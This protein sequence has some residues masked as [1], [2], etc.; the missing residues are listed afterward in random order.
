[1]SGAA[2]QP[3][4][5]A[6]GLLLGDGVEIGEGVLIGGYADHPCRCD[7]RRR[8]ADRR[9]RAAARRR[10]DRRRDDD[11]QL[12][13]ASTPRSRS[14]PGSACRPAA[15]SPAAPSIEDDVF[16]GPG[17]TLTNDNTMDRHEPGHAFRRSRSCAAPAG[18][19]AA[20]PSVPGSRSARR[21]SSPP[22]RSSPPTCRRAPSSPASPPE[23]CARSPTRICSSAGASRRYS[24]PPG[25]ARAGLPT[26]VAP[27]ATSRVT[28]APAPTAPRRRS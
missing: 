3:S 27:G 14:A 16:V 13:L 26:T 6:P 2:L 18:S 4:P 21:P 20:R 5:L 23:S 24:A 10:Q 25:S 22:A 12:Q 7:D 19:A 11:R 8:S 28:T 15:T 9:P 1:M 17:V